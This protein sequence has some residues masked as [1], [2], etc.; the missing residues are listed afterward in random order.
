[1]VYL[2]KDTKFLGIHGLF[3][4]AGVPLGGTVVWMVDNQPRLSFG[5]LPILVDCDV[6]TVWD[7]VNECNW[8]PVALLDGWVTCS[9][10]EAMDSMILA[11]HE[12]GFQLADRGW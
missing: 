9:R 10:Q 8:V 3:L 5:D 2:R 7:E 12:R 4:S 1:M 6:A 11:D